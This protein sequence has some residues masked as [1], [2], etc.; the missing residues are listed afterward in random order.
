MIAVLPA[1]H[2]R[3]R[4]RPVLPPPRRVSTAR[5]HWHAAL[6]RLRTLVPR[7]PAA[8]RRAAATLT[9]MTV[10]VHR[11]EYDATPVGAI[12]GGRWWQ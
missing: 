11:P 10:L 8:V 3:H 9:D 5:W 12:S 6:L 4:A 1:P 7:R 2:G